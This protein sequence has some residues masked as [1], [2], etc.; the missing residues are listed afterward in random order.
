MRIYKQWGHHFNPGLG[1]HSIRLPGLNLQNAERHMLDMVVPRPG[2]QPV[3]SSD[4][5]APVFAP[6]IVAGRRAS[7][8]FVLGSAG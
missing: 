4:G 8:R 5:I 2:W 7:S 1:N 6:T 3:Q